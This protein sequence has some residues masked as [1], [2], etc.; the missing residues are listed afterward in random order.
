MRLVKAPI[1]MDFSKIKNDEDFKDEFHSLSQ[2]NND[3]IGVW[4]KNM[5]SRGKISDENEAIF[6]LLVELHRKVDALSS[7][8]RS[9]LPLCNNAL[10]DSIGHGLLI[11]R[12]NVLE[13]NS[14]YYGRISIAVFPQRIIPMYFIAKD[15]KSAN[16]YL[17]HS[18]DIADYDSYIASRERAMIREINKLKEKNNG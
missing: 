5:R 2:D 10:L 16:I 9:Y 11:F 7:K 12:D 14:K 18:Q 4:I 15:S 3:P 13:E 1:S 6:Q 8:E 17:M